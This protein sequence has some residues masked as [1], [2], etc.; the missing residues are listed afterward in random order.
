[1]SYNLTSQT[2]VNPNSRRTVHNYELVNN[3]VLDIA[4]S[5]K[6]LEIPLQ[7]FNFNETC[8]MWNQNFSLRSA[9]LSG[10]E[11]VI[12]SR[13]ITSSAGYKMEGTKIGASFSR[14][15]ET[16]NTTVLHFPLGSSYILSQ[17]SSLT[18][19]LIWALNA[20]EKVIVT[21]III[22]II[23]AVSRYK[24]RHGCTVRHR[25]LLT[26]LEGGKW[27]GLS[28]AVTEARKR[29]GCK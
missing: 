22:I 28:I 24:R 12:M 13:A 25:N 5:R 27:T 6:D 1:M 4:I 18:L 16:L 3:E 21:I 7:F 17:Y 10:N 11:H 2:H 23:G 8:G 15:V 19:L 20:R 9:Q 14:K 29:V 26:W